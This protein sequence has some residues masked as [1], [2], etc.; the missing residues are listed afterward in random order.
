ML[1]LLKLIVLSILKHLRQNLKLF[2][3][4]KFIFSLI[5][6]HCGYLNHWTLI[7]NGNRRER[8]TISEA[9]EE[10]NEKKLTA[11]TLFLTSRSKHL[12]K[13]WPL[14]VLL[15]SNSSGHELHLV[16]VLTKEWGKLPKNGR[17]KHIVEDS[18]NEKVIFQKF[19]LI[20][21]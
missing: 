16:C 1:F 3:P 18:P 11:I 17:T 8:K 9:I 5:K 4:V 10:R 12:T 15:D 2:V 6:K 19:C 20:H 13:K 14:K 7:L 21:S